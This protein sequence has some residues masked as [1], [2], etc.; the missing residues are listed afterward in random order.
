MSSRRSQSKQ[1][2]IV[3]VGDE[4]VVKIIKSEFQPKDEEA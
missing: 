3:N 4:S 1:S 2:V